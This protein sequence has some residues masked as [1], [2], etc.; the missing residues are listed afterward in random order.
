MISFSEY[1]L[2]PNSLETKLMD[3]GEISSYLVARRTDVIPSRCRTS[4]AIELPLDYRA[5]KK[6]SIM[7][8]ERKKD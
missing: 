6:L 4:N 8:T 2:N 5:L 7:E 3:K 1:L